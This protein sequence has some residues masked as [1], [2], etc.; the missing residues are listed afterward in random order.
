MMGLA[1]TVLSPKHF[2]QPVRQPLALLRQKP[3][4]AKMLAMRN[5]QSLPKGQAPQW[6]AAVTQFLGN[7]LMEGYQWQKCLDGRR[8]KDAQEG[9]RA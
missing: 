9:A 5:N 4:N 7:G 2:L 6:L 3:D 8:R 1:H